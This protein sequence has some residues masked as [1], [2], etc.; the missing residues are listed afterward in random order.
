MDL[1]VLGGSS[2]LRLA[3][4][5]GYRLGVPLT[6]RVVE[7]FPDGEIHVQILDSVRGADLYLIQSAVIAPEGGLLEMLLL[8]DACRRAGSARVTAVMPYLPYA[9]QDRRATGREAVGARVVADFLG[10]GK[11]DRVIAIDLHSA[12]LEG[13]FAVPVEHLT[14]VPL[15]VD[16]LRAGVA[17]D[18]VVV[19]PD[20]GAAKLADRYAALLGLPAAMVHKTRESG[21]R[22]RA[23]AIAG[24][25]SG[26]AV[27]IVDDMI[28]TGG[29]NEAAVAALRTAGCRAELDIAATH[30]LLVGGAVERLQRLHPRRITVTDSALHRDLPAPFEVLSVAA[31][32]ADAIGRLHQERSLSELVMHA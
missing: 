25:V 32:L 29:T 4:A 17:R 23:G 9:R 7:R 21:S 20:L 8:S 28:S 14:A 2:G 12:A 15:L 11:F 10:A 22:V 6:R 16:A 19:A 27:L 3:E 5:I 31:L 18:T 1:A 24:D 30:G 13:V 26:R